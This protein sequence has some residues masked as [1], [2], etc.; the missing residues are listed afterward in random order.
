MTL[1]IGTKGCTVYRA[2][3]EKGFNGGPIQVKLELIL[4]KA[5]VDT[6]TDELLRLTK[7]GLVKEVLIKC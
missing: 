1:D 2:T 5:L 4:S 6:L 3:I 7:E